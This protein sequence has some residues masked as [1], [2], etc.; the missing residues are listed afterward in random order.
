MSKRLSSKW[1]FDELLSSSSVNKLNNI[2]LPQLGSN[3]AVDR[4]LGPGDHFLYFNPSFSQLSHDGYF[5]YQTPGAL[6]AQDLPFLRRVWVQGSIDFLKPLRFNQSYHCIETI[7][8]LKKVRGDYFVGIR[9]EV[10]DQSEVL[11][12]EMRTLL[13]TNSKPLP[14]KATGIFAS[15]TQCTDFTFRDMDI[16]RYN[17]LTFNSHRIHWDKQY[18]IEKEGYQDFIAQ[19][20]FTIHVMLKYAASRLSVPVRKIKYKNLNYIYQ[21]TNVE[22]CMGLIV[23]NK[24]PIWIRDAKDKTVTYVEATLTV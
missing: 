20:P 8:F 6:S 4:E 23:E 10:T 19:G 9:R 12:K 18:C 22:I 1:V 2:L 14:A 17:S 5:Q 21:G 7:K 16:V 11:L 3:T 15:H 13:Y 24:C